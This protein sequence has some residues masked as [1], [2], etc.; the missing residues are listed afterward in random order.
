MKLISHNVYLEPK[1]KELLQRLALR[2]RRSQNDL[3]REAMDL[4]GEKYESPEKG[5]CRDATKS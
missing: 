4:L 3:A 1:Q 2:F 5:E